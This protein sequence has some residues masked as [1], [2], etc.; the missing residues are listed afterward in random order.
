MASVQQYLQ[1]DAFDFIEL[2]K[3]MIGLSHSYNA[4]WWYV[5]YYEVMVLILFPFILFCI[6]IFRKKL[7]NGE[8]GKY[9]TATVILLSFVSMVLDRRGKTGT[10]CLLVFISGAAFEE[11]IDDYGNIFCTP[12]FSNRLTTILLAWSAFLLRIY[13]TGAGRMAVDCLCMPLMVPGI[14]LLLRYI[15]WLKHFLV[16]IGKH[17]T[18]MWLV[19]SLLY[20]YNDVFYCF[21][22]GVTAYV[23]IVFLSLFISIAYMKIL[24]VILK[25]G[26]LYGFK[27]VD[28]VE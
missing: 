1:D 14:L 5:I 7:K 4:A 17:S 28:K 25:K 20:K 19:H 8:K 27:A 22:D 21:P 6:W 23:A 18:I 15:K 2:I 13:T 3:N 16:F 9:F 24:D 11:Y 10:L 12:V 26:K